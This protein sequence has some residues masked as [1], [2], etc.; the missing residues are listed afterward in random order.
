MTWQ[1]EHEQE[2]DMALYSTP[3]GADMAGPGISRCTYGGFCLTYPPGRMYAVF[4]DPV[5]AFC[6]TKAERLLAAAI[7]YCEERLV[8][9]VAAR[10]PRLRLR[11]YAAHLGRR[12]VYLPIGQLSPVQ[13]RRIRTFHI[14]DGHTVRK[15][16]A[17]YIR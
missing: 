3:P 6:R 9:Y 8:M 14:L 1:G 15:G 16:A 4:Q 12:V 17:R 5:Y 13:V 11:D 7:D 2:S 10:P